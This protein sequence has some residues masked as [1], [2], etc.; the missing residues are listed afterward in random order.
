MGKVHMTSKHAGAKARQIMWAVKRGDAP[1]AF[2]HTLS[3]RR[4][5]AIA[6]FINGDVNGWPHFY[7]QGYRCV[8]FE[9]T[10][11]RKKRKASK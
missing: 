2:S 10:E 4:G 5:G 7:R 11:V 3:Y 6:E 8:R 1:A 9:I